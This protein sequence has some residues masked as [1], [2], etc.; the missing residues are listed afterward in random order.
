MKVL[1]NREVVNAPWGGGNNFVRAFRE[2]VPQH[3][4]QIVETLE[5][6]PDVVLLMGP[7]ADGMG[8]DAWHALRHRQRD[9]SCKV[10]FRLNDCDARKETTGVDACL[11]SVARNCDEL[12]FVSRWL[13]DH[14]LER[15]LEIHFGG[16][17][18]MQFTRGSDRVEHFIQS[19]S[20]VHNGVDTAL[21][22]SQHI[23]LRDREK[24]VAHHWSDNP[25]KGRD[26]YEALDSITFGVEFTYIGRHQCVFKNP[27]TRVVPPCHGQELASALGANS[28]YVTGTR[29]DPGPNHVLEA[30]ACGLP[31]WVHKNGGGAVEFAGDNHT[32]DDIE[33]LKSMFGVG[34]AH[35]D[36][37]RRLHTPN[38]YKPMT[39]ESCIARYV[40]VFERT[41]SHV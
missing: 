16:G 29:F 17:F 1:I 24:I 14:L 39:W 21:F 37:G 20:V 18:A 10:I 6:R 35:T 8:I 30:L 25:L 4:H 38:T 32:F 22:K 12:V 40:E 3:G 26:V 36:R 15:W 34:S 23:E 5:E 19:A 31:V 11:W 41:H 27:H 33:Q 7:D 2:I 13:Q 28:V 9:K